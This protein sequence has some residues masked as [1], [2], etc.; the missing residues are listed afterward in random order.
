MSYLCRIVC[1]GSIYV[2]VCFHHAATY[3]THTLHTKF[4]PREITTVVYFDSRLLLAYFV[5]F[6]RWRWLCS[7][8]LRPSVVV[9]SCPQLVPHRTA[10]RPAPFVSP[11]RTL[12]A[13]CCR[14]M[15]CF[16]SFRL[17]RLLFAGCPLAVVTCDATFRLRLP[18]S[19]DPPIRIGTAATRYCTRAQ[20]GSG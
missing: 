1:Q 12:T 7:C 3:P 20:H 16:C 6:Q 10:H 18:S 9:R 19:C 8:A 14:C 4:Y 11:L 13:T 2:R 15:H 5:L 17:A